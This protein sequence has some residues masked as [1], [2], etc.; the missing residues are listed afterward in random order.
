MSVLQSALGVDR[1]PAHPP[2]AHLVLAR[3]AQG[4][5]RIWSGQTGFSSALLPEGC[6]GSAAATHRPLSEG[7]FVVSTALA[8]ALNSA[9]AGGSF[10]SG[11]KVFLSLVEQI[12]RK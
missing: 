12:C 2:H 9:L 8:V 1:L 5:A 11:R 4:E 7:A 6:A 3:N 10:I